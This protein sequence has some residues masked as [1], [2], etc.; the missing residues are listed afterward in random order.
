VVPILDIWTDKVS[1]QQYNRMM[2]ASYLRTVKLP[3]G[4]FTM[5]SPL[6]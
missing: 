4:G 2:F 6:L 1:F 3:F 5:K